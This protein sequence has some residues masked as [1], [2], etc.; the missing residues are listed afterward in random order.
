M[1]REETESDGEN[2]GSPTSM[3]STLA[4]GLSGG[5]KYSSSAIMSSRTRTGWITSRIG[6]NDYYLLFC[7]GYVARRWVGTRD[8]YG[9]KVKAHRSSKVEN[10]SERY[11]N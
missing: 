3:D 10:V 6:L 9:L 11:E 4:D 8:C 1:P 5:G 7:A 2:S